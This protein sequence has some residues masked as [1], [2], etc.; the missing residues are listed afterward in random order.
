[1]MQLPSKASPL[2]TVTLGDQAFK[3]STLK[4]HLGSKQG[5]HRQYTSKKENLTYE[6]FLKKQKHTCSRKMSLLQLESLKH[7]KC[8]G[9]GGVRSL[10]D[11]SLS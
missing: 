4:E 11:T 7:S 3:I 10:C 5:V 6:I 8:Y 2:H 9:R 1:M